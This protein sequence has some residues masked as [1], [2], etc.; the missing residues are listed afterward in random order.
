MPMPE[1]FHNPGPC[2]AICVSLTLSRD[3]FENTLGTTLAHAKFLK[4]VVAFSHPYFLK[5]ANASHLDSFSLLPVPNSLYS[6]SHFRRKK[7]GR[8]PPEGRDAALRASGAAA[9]GQDRTCPNKF[10]Q[11]MARDD[12]SMDSIVNWTL[13]PP[14]GSMVDLVKG[15]REV[16]RLIREASFDSL[17][18]EFSL[19]FQV[20]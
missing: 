12:E 13:D 9:A 16:R 7:S 18:S 8:V 4:S 5:K 15:A 14:T 19:D 11:T 1:S 6:L 2:G 20:Q 10:N 17:A 3:D